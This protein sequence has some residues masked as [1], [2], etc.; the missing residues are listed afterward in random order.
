MIEADDEIF[1]IADTKHIQTVCELQKLTKYRRIMI[2]GG[3]LVG[4]GLA[5]QLEADHHVKLIEYNPDRAQQLSTY[6]NKTIVFC[7]ASDQELLLEENVDQV[8]AFIAVTNDDEANIMSALLAA[9]GR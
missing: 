5:R 1:F 6:L 8:D 2:V 4:A 9:H 3:G 7:D